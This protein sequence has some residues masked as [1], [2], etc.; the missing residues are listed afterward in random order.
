MVP[1]QIALIEVWQQGHQ[2][3]DSRQYHTGTA[4]SSPALAS[5]T[6]GG[7]TQYLFFYVF[8]SP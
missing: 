6:K 3:E 2:K 7:F 8:S 4:H 1:S 5:I